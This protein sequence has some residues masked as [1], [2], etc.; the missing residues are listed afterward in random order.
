MTAARPL[1]GPN[2]DR[3][4]CR[5]VWCDGEIYALHVIAYS[6]GDLPCGH[7]GCR[8]YLPADYRLTPETTR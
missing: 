5:C 8:R 3:V 6:V 2:S 7:R 1:R 4:Y